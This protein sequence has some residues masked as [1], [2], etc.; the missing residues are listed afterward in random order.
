M[1]NIT[2]AFS[3]SI[4]PTHGGYQATTAS[5]ALVAFV[6][7]VLMSEREGFVFAR[8]QNGNR[9]IGIFFLQY[10]EKPLV[11]DCFL[12]AFF[13]REAHAGEIT[14]CQKSPVIINSTP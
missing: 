14:E 4:L 12:S 6:A 2:I 3:S 9:S 11:P 8:I 1:K 5:Y 10:L 13:F 7:T